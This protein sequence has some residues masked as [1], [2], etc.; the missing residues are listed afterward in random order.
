MIQQMTH[1]NNRAAVVSS[2]LLIVYIGT[3]LPILVAGFLS[4]HFGFT[5]GIVSFCIGIGALCGYLLF[6]HRSINNAAP[7]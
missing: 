7:I 2:Y 4:D 5:V 6:G 3:I 1:S